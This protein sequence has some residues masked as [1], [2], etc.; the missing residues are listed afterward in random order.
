MKKLKS[1]ADRLILLVVRHRERSTVRNMARS[2]LTGAEF[3]QAK[4]DTA[5]LVT[6]EWIYQMSRQTR[7]G[8]ARRSRR[9]SLT[10]RLTRAG[11]WRA[12]RLGVPYDPSLTDAVIAKN[13]KPAPY[14]RAE[15]ELLAEQAGYKADALEYRRQLAARKT[16]KDALEKAAL[17]APRRKRSARHYQRLAAFL[18]TRKKLPAFRS[19]PELSAAGKIPSPASVASPPIGS[20]TWRPEL[21]RPPEPPKPA[22][23]R[24]QPAPSNYDEYIAQ[25]YGRYSRPQ[26]PPPDFRKEILE[27]AKGLGYPT[28]NEVGHPMEIM[29][30][31]R[32]IPAQEWERYVP[33]K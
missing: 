17:A 9:T 20:T 1:P 6:W 25:N 31:S 14:S 33:E 21:S 3:E 19:Q 12:A 4:R 5:G 11:L 23:Q 32:W 28:R 15:K 18:A 24:S 22:A 7:Y 10:A 27:R 2:H 13:D 29:Y 16:A 26:K 30:E 8:V